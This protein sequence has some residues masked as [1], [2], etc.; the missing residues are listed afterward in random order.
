MMSKFNF[1]GPTFLKISLK[2]NMFL[3][4]IDILERPSWFDQLMKVV[5]DDTRLQI[6]HVGYIAHRHK[7]IHF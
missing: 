5:R 1:L 4:N 3:I 6:Q 7:L 2:N